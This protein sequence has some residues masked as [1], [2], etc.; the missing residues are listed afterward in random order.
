MNKHA[1]KTHWNYTTQTWS[2][3]PETAVA[4]TKTG[5]SSVA[6]STGSQCSRTFSHAFSHA[7]KA[8]LV[9]LGFAGMGLFSHTVLAATEH[10]EW[11]GNYSSDWEDS[12]NW[13]YSSGNNQLPDAD[14][15]VYIETTNPVEL[16]N[17]L[18]ANQTTSILSIDIMSGGALRVTQGTL[19]TTD[20]AHG[21]D[22]IGNGT[23]TIASGA[24]LVAGAALMKVGMQ[25]GTTGTLTLENNSSATFQ[26]LSIGYRDWQYARGIKGIINIGDNVNVDVKQVAVGADSYTEGT[27]NIGDNTTL[28][29]N[30]DL[31]SDILI[32]AGFVSSK[33]MMTVGDNSHINLGAAEAGIGI[34]RSLFSVGQHG[35]GEATL[36]AGSSITAGKVE[37]G[38]YENAVGR[39][40][41]LGATATATHGNI[42]LAG[43]TNTR[44]YV[45]INQGTLQ[46]L[47]GNPS[48][49]SIIIGRGAGSEATVSILNGTLRSAGDI[50]LAS[51]A[52]AK[53]V[54]SITNGTVITDG[55]I[56]FGPGRSEL[57]AIGNSVIE[58]KG[59]RIAGTPAS[60]F[61]AFDGSIVRAKED[62]S[63]FLASNMTLTAQAG[64]AGATIDSN[65][66]NIGSSANFNI[67]ADSSFTKTG[68]GNLTINGQHNDLRGQFNVNQGTATLANDQAIQNAAGV[69]VT[70]GATLALG[71]TSQT[72]NN[73][74]GATGANV[75][76]TGSITLNNTVNTAYSGQITN[77]GIT[78]KAGAGTLTLDGNL[79]LNTVNV[80][81]GRLALQNNYTMGTLT[82]NGGGIVVAQGKQLNVS[83]TLTA[84]NGSAVVVSVGSTPAIIADSI[85][86]SGTVNLEVNGLDSSALSDQGVIIVQTTNG[87]T[88]SYTVTGAGLGGPVTLANYISGDVGTDVTGKNIVARMGLVWNHST[89]AHGTFN[90]AS[91]DSFS[92]SS[93]LANNNNTGALAFGW[94]GKD[95]TKTGSGDLTLTGANTYTGTTNVSAGS[96]T[97]AGNN[98]IASSSAVNL[99]ANSVLNNTAST[100]TI[101]SLTGDNSTVFNTTAAT[102][103]IQN[104]SAFTGTVNAHGGGV[105]TLVSN[106]SFANAQAFNLNRNTPDTA[107]EIAI[108]NTNQQFNMLASTG[109]DSISGGT[110]TL[111]LDYTANPSIAAE[112]GS[113]RTSGTVVQNGAELSLHENSQAAAYQLNT[114]RLNIA[115]GKRLSVAGDV[116]MANG[117]TLGLDLAQGPQLTAQ[118]L[119]LSGNNTIDITSMSGA[120]SQTYTLVST[121]N[122]INGTYDVTVAGVA[123]SGSITEDVFVAGNV[124]TDGTG[125]NI[126]G[127]MGLI[128]NN[129]SA[130]SA[131]GTFKVDSGSFTVTDLQNNT[132]AGA[133]GFGWNGQDLTKRGA[134]ELVV[135]GTNGYTGIT[136]VEAGT[137]TLATNNTIASSSEIAVDAAGRLQTGA[138]QQTIARLSGS[139]TVAANG[140]SLGVTD[141]TGF[142]GTLD[143]AGNGVTLTADN[144]FT[145]ANVD[146]AANAILNTQA[147]EQ[148]FSTLTGDNTTA[149]NTA[150]GK[151]GVTNSTGFT[152]ALN[153]STGT[154]ELTGNDVVANAS[155]VNLHNNAALNINAT[156]Q[157]LNNL[158]A[159][160]GTTIQTG[161]GQLNLAYNADATLNGQLTGAGTVT[162]LG[163]G[164]LNLGAD[165]NI[166][167]L[168]L[169]AGRLNAHDSTLNVAGALSVDAGTTLGVSATNAPSVTAGLA[170]FT[171]GSK[172]DV[173]GFDFDNSGST[174]LLS[175]TGGVTGS[176]QVT[177]NGQTLGNTID[178]NTY[179]HGSAQT[180][181]NDIVADVG[182]VWDH[183]NGDT[184]HGTFHIPSGET[185]A[186]GAN[187]TDNAAAGASNTAGTALFGWD[188]T[189]LTKESDGTLI[190]NGVNTYSG[191]TTVNAGTLLVGGDVS[192][193]SASVAGDVAVSSGAVL[194]GHGSILGTVDL[195]S[196]AT[197]SPGSSIGSL[198]VGSINFATGSVFDVDVNDDGTSDK[199]NVIGAATISGGTVNVLSGAG[200]WSQSYSYDI[201]EAGSLSGTFDSVQTNLAFLTPELAYTANKVT[202]SLTRNA[203]NMGSIGWTRNQR[204][205]GY[206][207]NWLPANHPVYNA[208]ISLDAVTANAAYDNLSGEIHASTKA[209]LLENSHYARTAINQR[210]LGEG[211]A[212]EQNLPQTHRG[213]WMSSWAHDGRLSSTSNT[214]KADSDGFGFLVGVDTE[215][216]AGNNTIVGIAAGYERSN[217]KI[218]G[219]RNSDAKVNAYHLMAYAGTTVGAID[220]RGGVGYSFLQNDTTRNIWV[221]GVQ[222]VSKADYDGSQLQL[223]VEGSHT[224]N[225]NEQTSVMPYAGLS[226]THL[227]MDSFGENGS[228]ASLRGSSDSANLTTTTL[229]VRGQWTFGANAQHNIHT[230]IGWQHNFG[231][232]TSDGALQ[233][234]GGLPYT[235]Q[236]SSL[237]DDKALVGVGANFELMPS[238]NLGIG[239]E[240]GFGSKVRSHTGTINLRWNF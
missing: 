152:G 24:R 196:G 217:V 18:S 63:N 61:L 43:D 146:L 69:S 155:Q 219:T 7:L 116:N 197:L 101:Q 188:G 86:F 58:T 177:V 39:L 159:D 145:N 230:N 202:L 27:L 130:G 204:S 206:S 120:S 96:L 226:Y 228:F 38:Q 80:N 238:L 84:N 212:V 95:L 17:R 48:Q 205:V 232:K 158:R 137:L 1:Y 135:T 36:G 211:L 127:S 76:G 144:S 66:F 114:G 4:R 172:I 218:G 78:N 107:Y 12:A 220:L 28:N 151:L 160:A 194:G 2:A 106:N 153:V 134:G 123:L 91:G 77:T 237:G 216:E 8:S 10:A 240:G 100:Q 125:N 25:D 178:I 224:F 9:T 133:P 71:N 85:N 156:T 37:V 229:G 181:G 149:I 164:T 53:G 46:T 190:L 143:V 11:T 136:S 21:I 40:V 225:I 119:N 124:Y 199:L 93:A 186:V 161:T 103:D 147:T 31:G 231:D 32:A 87:I 42:V 121:T 122:G 180:V 184:A 141:S 14:D 235:V 98:T 94:N 35:N 30:Y 126:V 148:T 34:G 15:F 89:T 79:N 47:A 74:T 6:V 49:K 182:L 200:A 59:F 213:L 215:L 75:T 67:A 13:Y 201:L 108:G 109:K 56:Y 60:I 162:K 44:A 110:G 223:F 23:L 99:A 166:G 20:S 57:A 88:G 193:A 29:G 3:V 207:I 92:L 5:S 82:L 221:D 73:L 168:N 113:I 191:V 64:S 203:V 26:N 50:T 138:T 33:G 176:Y 214:A 22:N 117:T 112:L 41:L 157:T 81:A 72:L 171:A 233:F 128:W 90:I 115:T 150:G 179:V 19:Q 227:K 68:A 154:L 169:N 132:T 52:T 165:A 97:L 102:L 139:G 192:Q 163:A 54:L 105:L 129:G 142:T 104:G 208:I 198:T 239:Y 222:G 185:F 45:V 167:A 131:H 175:T 118:S 189:T 70:S 183:A 62:A 65:G 140:G 170:A 16:S 174:V 55:Y 209:A 187:L 236:G 195:S 51:D 111:T 234:V 173:T 210:L 83:G